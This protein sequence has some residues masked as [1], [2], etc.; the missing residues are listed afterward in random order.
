[1]QENVKPD[2]FSLK[3]SSKKKNLSLTS[4]FFLGRKLLLTNKW[5]NV[6]RWYSMN[7]GDQVGK[8]FC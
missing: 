6:E 4:L 2:M 5:K 7:E 3:L 1:M 8:D